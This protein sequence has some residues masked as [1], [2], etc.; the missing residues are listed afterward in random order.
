MA[1]AEQKEF[2]KIVKQFFPEYFNKKIV[3]EVGS[4]DINGNTRNE[5]T[6]C[7]YTGIDVAAGSNVDVVC[8]GQDF[9]GADNYF[10]VVISCEV[11]EH[12]PFWKETMKNMIRVCKND[13][14]VIMSCATKGRKEHGTARTD[15]EASPL[16]VELGWDYYKNLT[17]N[18]FV[19]ADITKD[20]DAVFWVNLN[21]FDLYMLGFKKG[22]EKN[23]ILRANEIKKLYKSMH[24][25][26]LKSMRRKFKSYLGLIKEQ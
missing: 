10:D 19:N 7:E 15:P 20:L 6:D 4:L 21:S 5:F 9:D 26:S 18:D 13:G 2:V 16:T 12:N 23:K 17:E 25:K 14:M 11:M 24:F 22:S 8:Q 1:H 3:L